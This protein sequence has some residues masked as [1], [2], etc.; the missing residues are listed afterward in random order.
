MFTDDRVYFLCIA[1]HRECLK[2]SR[3]I[4]M[5]ALKFFAM[6]KLISDSPYNLRMIADASVDISRYRPNIRRISRPL[7]NNGVCTPIF[8]VDPA[9][10]H[11]YIAEQ[12][13]FIFRQQRVCRCIGDVLP[14]FAEYVPTDRRMVVDYR[15]VSANIF[16]KRSKVTCS[17]ACCSYGPQ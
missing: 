1:T 13:R 8:A 12:S 9:I 17:T 4:S 3:E 11:G 5:F 16:I 14:N 7:N 10:K 2:T 15:Y 6:L